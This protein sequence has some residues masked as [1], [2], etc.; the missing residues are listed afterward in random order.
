MTTGKVKYAPDYD[1]DIQLAQVAAAEQVVVDHLRAKGLL[2]PDHTAEH[3]RL[4]AAVV[5]AAKAYSLSG[6][7][8][9]TQSN[10]ILRQGVNLDEPE[11]IAERLL[12]LTATYGDPM[13]TA[14]QEMDKAVDALI[15][16]EAE[17]KI[18]AP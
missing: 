12:E 13:R 7:E 8:F 5:E 16:F 1:S 6:R 2:P 17:H 4:Q 15:A 14:G 3:Q 18:G 10:V 9:T 11:L